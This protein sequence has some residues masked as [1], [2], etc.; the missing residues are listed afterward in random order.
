MHIDYLFLRPHYKIFASRSFSALASEWLLSFLPFLSYFLQAANIPCGWHSQRSSVQRH[1][2]S[3]ISPWLGRW[4]WNYYYTTQYHL[5]GRSSFDF[6]DTLGRL[7]V[8]AVRF[9]CAYG[10]RLTHRLGTYKLLLDCLGARLGSG[11]YVY[12]HYLHC[13]RK[14]CGHRE[15]RIQQKAEKAIHRHTA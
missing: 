5:G 13:P 9:A 14:A 10:I 15:E 1:H 3:C 11:V 6:A 12:G 4:Q 2:F 7:F 8:F